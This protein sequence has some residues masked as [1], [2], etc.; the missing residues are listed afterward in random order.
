MAQAIFK[1]SPPYEFLCNKKSNKNIT[2]E[3]QLVCKR[4]KIHGPDW[5][6][7]QHFH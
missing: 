7:R 2:M 4:G 3:G 5:P 6:R 1:N